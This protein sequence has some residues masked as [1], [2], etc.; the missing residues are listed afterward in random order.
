MVAPSWP[1]TI[2]W[3][4]PRWLVAADVDGGE[5]G[6]GRADGRIRLAAALDR[7]DVERIGGDEVRTAVR[8]EWDE[9]SD[10]LRAVTERTLDALVLD[11][12]RGTRPSRRRHHGRARRPGHG[13]RARCPRLDGLGPGPPGPGR[14]GPEGPGRR[15]ARRLGSGPG[16]ASERL[17]R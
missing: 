7:D 12:S 2:P 10:D 3:P 14:L 16:R 9:A 15:L 13:Y 4:A 8:L 5:G 11:T 6:P 17:A 1:T